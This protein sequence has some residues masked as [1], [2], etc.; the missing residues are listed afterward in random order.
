MAW[1]SSNTTHDERHGGLAKDS[2]AVMAAQCPTDPRG[3]SPSAG[4]DGDREAL[5]ANGLPVSTESCGNLQSCSTAR[6]A[7]HRREHREIVRQKLPAAN[8]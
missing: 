4:L 5:S 3:P 7:P 1:S 6:V 8:A 2:F